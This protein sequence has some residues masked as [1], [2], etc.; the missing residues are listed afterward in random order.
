MSFHAMYS[1]QILIVFFDCLLHCFQSFIGKTIYILFKNHINLC[2]MASK[3]LVPAKI[4][5]ILSKRSSNRYDEIRDWNWLFRCRGVRIPLS[6]IFMSAPMPV[7]ILSAMTKSY[8][9]NHVR[10]L[11]WWCL[12]TIFQPKQYHHLKSI[13][14]YQ[15][16]LIF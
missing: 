7:R 9:W 4:D 6:I 8:T 16:L 12:K 1:D 2:W 13:F 14:V 15:K 3:P 10:C 11:T 5:R